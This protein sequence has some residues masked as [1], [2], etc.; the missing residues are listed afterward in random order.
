M[1]YGIPDKPNDQPLFAGTVWVFMALD[2]E[3]GGTFIYIYIQYI[4]IYCIDIYI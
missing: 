4:Y 2:V 1:V 3:N